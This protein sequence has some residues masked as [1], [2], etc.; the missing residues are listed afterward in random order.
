MNYMAA[1]PDGMASHSEKFKEVAASVRKELDYFKSLSDKALSE[2]FNG[3]DDT[4][5]MLR[6]NFKTCSQYVEQVMQGLDKAIDLTGDKA[7]ESAQRLKQT[8]EHNTSV[9][10]NLRRG[11][12]S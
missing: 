12:H 5:Q 2:V 11:S 4:S 8:E 6:D 10:Q 9:A 7:K 3:D 1:N